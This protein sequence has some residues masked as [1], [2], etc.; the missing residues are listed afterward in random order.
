MSTCLIANECSVFFQFGQV[1]PR[2]DFV[3]LRIFFT[4]FVMASISLGFLVRLVRSNRVCQSGL[5]EVCQS[6]LNELLPS[7]SKHSR[8][9]F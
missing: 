1:F 7:P 6:E 8:T 4:G 3:L 5:G 9:P 2:T